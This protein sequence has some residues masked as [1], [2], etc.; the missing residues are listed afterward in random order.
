M[1]QYAG[2]Y[3]LQNYST[4]F[5]CPSQPSWG[6]HKT[7]TAASGTG[8]SVWATIRPR[9]RKVVAQ[10]LR[11][12]PEAAVTVLCIPDDWCDDTRNMLSNFAVNKYLHT[13]ASCWILLIYCISQLTFIPMLFF[14]LCLIFQVTSFL[15]SGF[16]TQQFCQHSSVSQLLLHSSPHF[17]FLPFITLTLHDHK[18]L[19]HT[20]ELWRRLLRFS[21]DCSL[22]SF[23]P[24]SV[25][26]TTRKITM[27]SSDLFP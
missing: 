1:Q 10:T 8:R 11:P 7:V 15:P 17:N 27:Q 20:V 21:K 6:V 18:Y 3:L 4:C 25:S 5:G 2:I 23:V 12:V 14:I 26:A 9:W 22:F 13:V 16:Y 24:Q 19:T